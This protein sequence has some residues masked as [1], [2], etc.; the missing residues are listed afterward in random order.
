MF[1]GVKVLEKYG[2]VKLNTKRGKDHYQ[3]QHEYIFV[4]DLQ[5]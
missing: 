4:L 1:K 3:K 5:K 2:F